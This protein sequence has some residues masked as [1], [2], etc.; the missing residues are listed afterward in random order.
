MADIHG[1][2]NNNILIGNGTRF[3]IKDYIYAYAGDDLIEG[4]LGDDNIYGGDGDDEIYGDFE[5]TA[6]NSFGGAFNEG[7][8]LIFAG[9][10]DDTVYGG[11]GNDVIVAS[12]GTFADR[13]TVFGGFGNDWVFTG[14]GDD[15]LAGG[16]GHDELRAGGGNDTLVGGFGNDEL[17]A[18]SGNDLLIGY[19]ETG[20][21]TTEVDTLWGG[22]GADIFA[23]GNS[24]G[25]AYLG[26]GYAIIEDF[27]KGVDD[28]RVFEDNI[29]TYQLG[30]SSNGDTEIRNQGGDLLAVV[31]DVNITYADLVSA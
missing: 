24:F 17:L 28:I 8:D 23:L 18:H 9:K 13:D 7:N 31:S 1:D 2:H 27:Q 26:S 30:Q 19:H 21:T 6:K 16:L 14:N 3:A 5:H 15:F 22:S 10:G 20:T 29:F 4:R 12:E 11:G 25:D